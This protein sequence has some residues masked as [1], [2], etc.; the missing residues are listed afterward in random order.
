MCLLTNKTDYD[1]IKKNILCYKFGVADD[2]IFYSDITNFKYCREKLYS[3]DISIQELPVEI[4]NMHHNC[5]YYIDYGFH[6]YVDQ[7]D[8]E[9]VSSKVRIFII[10]K[11][12]KVY[13]GFVNAS[14]FKGYVSDRIIYTGYKNTW[15]NRLIVKILYMNK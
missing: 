2:Q 9:E 7:D 6:S 8:C 14:S 10:P 11:G 12:S 4:Q 3:N 15:L 5:A 1:I 13:K